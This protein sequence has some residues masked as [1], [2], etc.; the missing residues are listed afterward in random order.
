[1]PSDYSRMDALFRSRPEF[2]DYMS[3]QLRKLELQRYDARIASLTQA[4]ATLETAPLYKLTKSECR[5]AEALCSAHGWTKEDAAFF[6]EDFQRRCPLLDAKKT[7]KTRVA[8]GVSS[9][10]SALLNS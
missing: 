5:Q 10:A 8:S 2:N 3:T 6:V 9:I 4:R 7:D 1:M